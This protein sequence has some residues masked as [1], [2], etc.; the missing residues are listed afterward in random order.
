MSLSRSQRAGLII[1]MDKFGKATHSCRE[2]ARTD[3]GEVVTAAARVGLNGSCRRTASATITIMSGFQLTASLVASLAWPVVSV[4]VLCVIWIKR[5][6]ILDTFNRSSLNQGRKIRR[7]KAGPLEVEWDQLI[8]STVKQVE[9]WPSGASA[10]ARVSRDL[11]T[12][13]SDAP[14]AAVLGAFARV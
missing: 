13:A 1:G 8:E 10:N 14:A 11:A 7:V 4:I 5:A 2:V 12:T 3:A 6:D 9:R